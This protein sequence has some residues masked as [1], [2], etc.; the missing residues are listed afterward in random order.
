MSDS[1]AKPY[2]YTSQSSSKAPMPI[3]IV[4]I[5][6]NEA[7]RIG[8]LL[9]D[10]ANQTY[11]SFE[12]VLVDSNSDDDTCRIAQQF[13]QSLP[14]LSIHMMNKRGV[15]LGRNTG[16]AL[17]QHERLLFL[18]A[19]VRL[20]ADFLARASRQLTNKSVLIA[21]V[22]L[23]AKAMP[24]RFK[25]GYH[26]FNVGIYATQFIFPTAIGA[27]L[28]SSKSIHERI[29]GFD[30]SITLCE[31]CDYVN[32]ASQ[33]TPYRMLP[34]SF[35]FDPRRLRQDGYVKTGAKY[36]YANL[37]RLCVGEIRGGKLDYKF[38]HYRSDP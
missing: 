22:Y 11:R 37:Y 15:A 30:Q 16:A 18:D 7:E 28:F 27:C 9:Q 36:L 25:L 2:S 12:V 31:D 5:T 38:G 4:I 33:L 14:E 21:G 8:R 34:M 19:D 24:H 32:R 26:L 20:E 13:H 1:I 3:S 23:N 10:L 17:S 29:N 6:L 35:S